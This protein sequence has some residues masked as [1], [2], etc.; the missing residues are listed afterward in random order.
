MSNVGP[1]L[2]HVKGRPFVVVAVR[3]FVANNH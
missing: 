3:L 2:T 1:N